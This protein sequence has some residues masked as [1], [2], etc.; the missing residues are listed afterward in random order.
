[1]WF[2]ISIIIWTWQIQ[3]FLKQMYCY[4]SLS[5]A[6]WWSFRR[7]SVIMFTIIKPETLLLENIIQKNFIIWEIS[8]SF[9]TFSLA[10]SYWDTSSLFPRTIWSTKQ[11]TWWWFWSVRLNSSLKLS[12]TVTILSLD[13]HR[14]VISSMKKKHEKGTR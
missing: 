13:L 4:I 2:S 6:A 8:R 9:S 3:S 12:S 11:T 10:S 14:S 5:W 1:V 7:I